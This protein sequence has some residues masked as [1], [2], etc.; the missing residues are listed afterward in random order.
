MKNDVFCQLQKQ[1]EQVMKKIKAVI[2]F[3]ALVSILSVLAPTIL[4]PQDK[5]DGR[6]VVSGIWNGQSVKYPAG[7]ISIKIKEGSSPS[8]LTTLFNQFHATNKGG[9][10]Q[11][12]WGW[13]VLPDTT[14]IMLVISALKQNSAVEIAEPNFII[15]VHSVPNDPYFNGTSPAGYPYQ[16][17]LRNT[18]QTPPTGTAHADIDAVDAWNISTGGSNVIIG[19]LDTGIPIQ[20]G[21]LS[22]PDL[23]DPNRIILGPDYSDDNFTTP[24]DLFGHGTHVTGIASAETNNSIG[25]AGV[26]WNNK[27]MVVKV[28]DQ[29]GYGTAQTFYNGVIYCVGEAYLNY[30]G[31]GL[32]INYSGGSSVPSSVM[33]S[34]VSIANSNNVTIVAS[35]GNDYGGSVEYPAAYSSSYPNVIAVSATDQNDVVASYSSVGPQVIVSAPGGWGIWVNGGITYYNGQGNLGMNI[36]ST[37]PNYPFNLQSGT[38]C[39]ENYGYLA[40]TSMAAPQVTGSVA[41]MLSIDPSLTPTQIRT[42]L[43][44]SA[45]KVAGMNGQNFTNQYGNG[46][47]NA[48]QAL[49]YTLENYGGTVNQIVT[50]PQGDTWTF[51]PGVTVKFASGAGLAVNGTL[52]AVGTSSQPITFTSTGST[53]PGSWGSIQFSGSGANGSTMSYANILYGTEVDIYSANNVTIENCNITNNSGDGIYV[54]SSTNFLAQSNIIKNTNIYHGIYINGGY[55]NNCFWNIISKTNQNYDGAGILYAGSSGLVGENDID[56]YN[57]GIAGIWNASPS[58]DKYPSVRNNRVTSCIEGLEIYYQS[59][60]MFGL[61]TGESSYALNSVYNNGYDAAVGLSYPTV[62]SSLY[63]EDDWWGSNFT[64]YQGSACTLNTS[65]PDPVDPWQSYGP[66]PTQSRQNG[67]EVTPRIAQNNTHSSPMGSIQNSVISPSTPTDSLFIG[68]TLRDQNMLKEARDFFMSYLNI[69][70]DNQAAYVY[71][72]SCADTGS[73]P[74][75]IQFFNNLP[76]Q[77]DNSHKLLLANLYL[78][79][80][81]VNSAKQVN[82]AIITANPN[83]P[84]AVRAKLNNLSIALDFEHDAGTA[85]AILTQVE[86]QASLT[87]PMELSTAEGAVKNYINPNAGQTP[88]VN[89]G[90]SSSST[91]AVQSASAGSLQNYPN[92]FN[93]TTT[94][95]YQIPTSGHVTIKVFDVLGRDVTTLVD[96]FKPA[97]RYTTLFDASRLASGIYFYSIKSSNYNAVKKMLLLK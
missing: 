81:D 69:H 20:N 28:F 19:I 34:A 2:M 43:E 15:H 18:G 90:Q 47:V 14:D 59:Y 75:I 71:L 10:D 73:I 50:I 45:N 97:G 3:C 65:N 85:S 72:Y 64:S 86:A 91:D 77:A 48:Y 79:Q 40:G 67:T 32:V 58:A 55:S 39:T 42:T 37:E 27:I 52:N 11:L 17:A 93:P 35:A 22:H 30:P 21:S 61:K 70:P 36:F 87:T 25:I 82:N 63:A 66:P 57:W 76:K 46:R 6:R 38:D 33:Q 26:S 89:A 41:L 8:A 1:K 9:F 53:S 95:S 94:I 54:S 44:N 68:V 78:M 23:S 13:I 88:N 7:E 16:W 24:M 4:L 56:Y 12:G 84:L 92:P 29:N 49:K 31:Y 60:G 83:T 51:S 5:I 80:G 62:F 74:A 96:E